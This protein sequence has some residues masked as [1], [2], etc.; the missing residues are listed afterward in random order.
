M[1]EDCRK[2]FS[3]YFPLIT[4]AD[5]P[6]DWQFQYFESLINGAEYDS[7]G[8]PTGSGKTSILQIWL[9]ALGWKGLHGLEVPIP[10]RL[11]WVVNRRVVVDQAT[12]EAEGIAKTINGIA[13]QDP[14]DPLICGLRSYSQS[15]KLLAVSTLRGQKADNREWS[16]DP[17]APAIVVGTVDM[18][19]SRLLF[20][21]YGD[22]KYWRPQ[23]AGLL[24]VDTLIVNDE[25]HLTPAFA[26]LLLELKRREPASKIPGK[27]FRILLVSATDGGRGEHPF[28][29]SLEKDL[30]DNE[31]FQRVYEAEKRLMLHECADKRGVESKML[32]L[33]L[34]PGALRTLV[35]IE[36]PEDAAQ[37]ADRLAKKAGSDR[38]CLL[39]GTMRGWERDQL[40]S[41]PVFQEFL[42]RELPAE[43]CWLVATS[44]AEVGVNLSAERMIT[45]LRESDHLQ[46]RLGRLNRFGDQDGEPHRVGVAHVLYIPPK[47]SDRGGQAALQ[48]TLQYLR[49]LPEVAP[50][51]F[52]VSC[53]A[54]TKS[55]PGPETRE[56][57]PLMCRL[58][59]R[60]IDLWSQTSASDG[61]PDVE[62]WLHGKQEGYAETEVLWRAD[63]EYLVRL[64]DE[65]REEA[66]KKYFVLPHE[67]LREPTSR[68]RKKLAEIAESAP[69]VEVVVVRRDGSSEVHAL[70]KLT[71]D[72]VDL[73]YCRVILPPGCGGL[74]KGML[75]A[76][77]SADPGET[78]FDVADEVRDAERKESGRR[79]YVVEFSDGR[80]K[81]TRIG[82][83]DVEEPEFDVDPTARREVVKFA[84]ERGLAPPVV[85]QVPAK[86]EDGDAEESQRCLVYFPGALRKNQR[87]LE[88]ELEEHSKAVAEKAACLA[89]RLLG[90]GF[91]GIYR[92]AGKLHDCGKAHALWQTAMGGDPDKPLAKTAGAANPWMLDGFRHELVSVLN[93]GDADP[94]VLHLIASHHGWA[95]PFWEHKAYDP[96]RLRASECAAFAAARRFGELQSR[97][98]PWGLAYLEA[99][100]RAADGDA[101]NQKEGK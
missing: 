4:G 52:D 18:I 7:I 65:D 28:P 22:G 13:D 50:G 48:A 57:D 8:L 37:F 75:Q 84:A 11:V 76:A 10:R 29:A 89:L 64:R 27:T 17:S 82:G 2:Y 73:A 86:D 44:A 30:Q 58:D 40:V 24:G 83:Q 101:S 34:E 81:W 90:P 96:K 53:R 88:I 60:V 72:D 33:A 70:N 99:L 41:D 15:G 92:T 71:G 78:R 5:S 87:K 51:V 69:E 46:Q 91:E 9:L 35:F 25:S 54:L 62:L 97:W 98:G 6:Y 63:V 66:L 49:T 59:D 39:T 31:R 32:E 68:V 43:P 100:F 94:L 23:H 26:E 36:S 1:R 80:W 85:F 61:M 95:R 47:S 77:G 55:S 45:M 56:P 12:A 19:G 74:S 16:D 79:R 42:K 67:V 20:R 14:S 38:V 21:G 3:S 93:A